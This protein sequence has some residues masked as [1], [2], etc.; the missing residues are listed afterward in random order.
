MLSDGLWHRGVPTQREENLRY[1]LWLLRQCRDRNHR[2]GVLAICRRDIVFWVN[3]FVYQYN[4]FKPGQE[5]GPFITWDFQDDALHELLWCIRHNQSAVIEKSREMGGTYLCVLLI[6]WACLFHPWKKFLVISRSAEAVDNPGD[7]DCVFWKIDQ[8]LEYLPDWM[9]GEV[10]RRK[11][12][13]GFPSGS[14]VTG[15]ASTG[16]AGVGG[17]ATAIFLD[18]FSQ[19][20]EDR[21]VRQRTASTTHCR[22]F[23]GTH[24]GVGTEFYKLCQQPE[25]K[26]IR[27]HWTQHPDKRQGL[28]RSGVKGGQGYEVLDRSHLFPPDFEFVKDGTPKGGYAPGVRSPWYDR[29][30]KDIG[31]KLGVA[32]DLDMDAR[33]SDSQIFDPLVIRELKAAYCRPP[34]WEGDLVYDGNTGEPD[35]L[36]RRKGG[37]IKLWLA[38]DASGRFP[39]MPAAFAADVSTG[40]GVTNS[41][42][43][44]ANAHTGEKFLEVATP[45]MDENSFATLAVALCRLFDDALLGWERQGPGEV[46]GKRV[47]ELGYH[48]VYRYR[49]DFRLGRGSATAPG[50]FPNPKSQRLLVNDYATALAARQFVN[51]SELALE[52][53]LDWK[54][55]QGGNVVHGGKISCRDPSGASVNHGDRSMAD[56]ILWLMIKPSYVRVRKVET[57]EVRPNTLAW[58]RQARHD[59]LQR[60]EQ[61][62]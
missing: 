32:M 1:R 7:P 40:Q 6:V 12:Y 38:P 3:S 56:A 61:W 52:E 51:P 44:G 60:E 46:F 5:Y 31:D 29:K 42:L 54:W 19:V 20:K 53:C 55:D 10:Q 28:Y 50:F 45:R 48:N 36:V 43:S 24:L 47:N 9:R 26:K 58:R 4:P 14:K 22:I 37:A 25:V 16:K 62:S 30:C 2:K 18:E 35:K 21:E 59:D 27:M 13:F 8:V 41:C 49:D 17:R 15:Q 11:M 57:E 39:P 33:G 34:R 23:N